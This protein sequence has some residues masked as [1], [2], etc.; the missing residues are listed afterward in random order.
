MPISRR[1]EIG[2]PRPRSSP[3]SRKALTERQGAATL[4]LRN[5]SNSRDTSTDQ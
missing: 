1:R 3:E 4:Q 2:A 5:P